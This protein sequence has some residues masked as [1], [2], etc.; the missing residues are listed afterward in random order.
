ML[1]PR[2][3]SL[4]LLLALPFTIHAASFDCTKAHT[5][6]EHTICDNPQLS[7]LDSQMGNSYI[8]VRVALSRESADKVLSDQREWLH[9]LGAVCSERG[10]TGGGVNIVPC[11]QT[12]YETRIAQLNNHRPLGNSVLYTRAH[13]VLV[14]RKPSDEEVSGNFPAFGIGSFS[15]PQVDRPTPQYADWN[16]A[17]YA[18]AVQTTAIPSKKSPSGFDSD[19]DGDSSIDVS[20]TIIAAN[21]NMI[22]TRITTMFYSYG[23]A[24][25]GTAESYF[26]WR[27]DDSRELTASDIFRSDSNW[28]AALKPKIIA[29]LKASPDFGGNILWASPALDKAATAELRNPYAWSVSR[30]GLSIHFAQYEVA[31]YVFGMPSA[32][33]RWSEIRS[34][35]NPDFKPEE[36]PAARHPRDPNP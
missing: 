35:L 23:A 8:T 17:V 33:L 22:A 14:Q 29:K 2:A 27:L 28:Q 7:A 1:R 34:L 5:P 6:L 16:R 25:P 36:L 13:F 12:Q 19:V 15:Y 32:E 31:A 3:V 30:S 11:L 20:C 18:A 21:D 10:E 9:W 26:S 24:H 4:A